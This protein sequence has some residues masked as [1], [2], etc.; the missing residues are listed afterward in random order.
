[1]YL[2]GLLLRKGREEEERDG[3]EEG[4]GGRGKGE[5]GGEKEGK[6]REGVGRFPA[7]LWHGAPQCLNPAL[8]TVE[9]K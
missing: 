9:H 5:R 8:L 1:M 2:G 6:G 7:T 4:M 3:A